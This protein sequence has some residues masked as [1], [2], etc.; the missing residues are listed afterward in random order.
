MRMETQQDSLEDLAQPAQDI[1][2]PPQHQSALVA[3]QALERHRLPQDME[4]KKHLHNQTFQKFKEK[5]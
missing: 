5:S 2:Q 4:E 3:I 1:A